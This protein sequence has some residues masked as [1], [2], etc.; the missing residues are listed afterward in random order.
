MQ[1]HRACHRAC[2]RVP[3][4]LLC[5]HQG[6]IVLD[7]DTNLWSV[8][9]SCDT[10]ATGPLLPTQCRYLWPRFHFIMV[11]GAD[12]VVL[13]DDAEATDGGVMR[14]TQFSGIRLSQ[15]DMCG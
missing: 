11:V 5:C 4:S 10:T 7:L 1:V 3:T 12:A 13:A 8:L 6:L 14:V 9:M 2:H 15:I